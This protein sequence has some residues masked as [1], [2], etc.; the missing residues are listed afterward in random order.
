MKNA[1]L[2]STSTSSTQVNGCDLARVGDPVTNVEGDADHPAAGSS[3]VCA[4]TLSVARLMDRTARGSQAARASKDVHVGDKKSDNDFCNPSNA[5][6]KKVM[7][8]I[9]A[10]RA[11]AQKLAD[12][13]GVPVENILGL[14]GLESGWGNDLAPTKAFNFFSL[15]AGKHDPTALHTARGGALQVFPSAT[16]FMSSGQ[17]FLGTFGHLIHGV[18]DSS[19]FVN[20]LIPKFNT[21]KSATGGDDL[22]YK[23]VTTA[24]AMVKNRINCPGAQP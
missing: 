17:A 18:S 4:R 16:G 13:A 8:F 3:S 22:F 19:D 9:R 6:N 11:D 12:Q 15:N 10:H 23:K 2:R 14:S 20:A 1:V 24:I 5:T 7:D 21:G